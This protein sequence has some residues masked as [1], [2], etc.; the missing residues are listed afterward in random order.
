MSF[1]TRGAARWLL[2]SF[3]PLL[4]AATAG[5]GQNQW[6]LLADG[7]VAGLRIATSRDEPGIVYAA[8]GANVV[9]VSDDLG[10]TWRPAGLK[11]GP[12]ADQVV[13]SRVPPEVVYV[14]GSGN[15]VLSSD[16]GSTWAAW[17]DPPGAWVQHV[18]ADLAGDPTVYMRAYVQVPCVRPGPFWCWQPRPYESRDY[19]CPRVDRPCAPVDGG[20]FPIFAVPGLEPLTFASSLIDGMLYRVDSNGAA[21]MGVWDGNLTQI[22]IQPDAVDVDRLYGLD[23]SNAALYR[24]DDRG[25]HWT[26][27]RDPRWT[28]PPEA[29][30]ADPVRTGSLFVAIGGV[31]FVSSDAGETWSPLG[32]FPTSPWP[33]PISSLA[34]NADAMTLY[35][36][37]LQG[38]YGYS[39]CEV[40]PL[41]VEAGTREP[42]PIEPRP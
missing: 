22:E 14:V 28:E 10:R 3:V 39:L 25:I 31:V 21:A 35:A 34:V 4:T 12:S 15:V 41:R 38:V 40:C 7:P 8:G 32:R 27:L 16:H 5:A 19:R 23:R 6:T 9:S 26:L 11:L 37:T 30:A 2:A 24:S 1:C 29:F 18:T 36:G 33:E 17:P 42:R 20:L 13:V